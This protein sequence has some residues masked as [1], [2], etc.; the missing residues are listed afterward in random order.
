MQQVF[1]R[2]SALLWGRNAFIHDPN[3]SSQNYSVDAL[4]PGD[5][6]DTLYWPDINYADQTRSGWAA[7][8]HYLRIQRLLIAGGID[9]FRDDQAYRER[10]IAALRYWLH[11]DFINPNWWHNEIGMPRTLS[12]ICIMTWDYLSDD[13][14]TRA[15]E[16]ISRGSI[17]GCPRIMDWTGANLIW[18][19]TNTLKHALLL[20][21][22]QLLRIASDRAIA[23]MRFDAEGIQ[24][25]GAFCQ[26][27]RRWYSGGY[28]ASFTFDVSILIHVLQGSAWAFPREALDIFL[29]HVL[30]GQR[31]MMKN[32]FFDYCGVGREFA[33]PGEIYKRNIVT[34]VNLLAQTE[35]LPRADEI[36]AFAKENAHPAT[37]NPESDSDKTV[38]YSSIQLLCHRKNSSYISVKGHNDKLFDQELCN[39][40]GEL[41][42][43]LSYGTHTCLCR[44][45]DEYFDIS[46]IWDY[47]H[48]PGT[49][50]R[51]ENDE[52]IHSHRGWWTQPLPNDHAGGLTLGDVGILYEKPEH[53]GI[54]ALVSFFTFDGCLVSLGA[55]I[56]DDNPEAGP[57]TTTV[58]QCLL[59]DANL[60]TSP[61][62]AVDNG[63]WSYYNLDP[64]TSF[65]ANA[66]HV[67]GSWRRNNHS[68]E[69]APV[70]GDVFTL[71]IE[72]SPTHPAFAYM[73][74]PRFSTLGNGTRVLRNDGICQAIVTPR[75][76][77][78]TRTLMAVFHA[79]G[80]LTLPDGTTLA[81]NRG[82]CLILPDLQ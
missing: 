13:V 18:G 6:P 55:D 57:L 50:A 72:H 10:L 25:D 23:E 71:Y 14:R 51:V 15:L 33:R 28:G 48:I 38:F 21:D 12:D 79:D 39:G 49:T 29:L 5:A 34:G 9:R 45:G 78:G 63:E 40:E 54:S 53:D 16:L 30:D 17:Q 61:A 3:V 59:R 41:A 42:Y 69:D 75:R 11:H 76:P 65:N 64:E 19:V 82:K 46:P 80:E 7:A 2:F 8:Q 73:V 44:R 24:E 35:D 22:E 68:V 1:N 62:T 47:A 37:I 66:K 81:G 58:D 20:G 56:R 4:A 60:G 67:V 70:E 32:G 36:A 27:G 74:T 77:D 52:Q 43:N 26:H 31:V